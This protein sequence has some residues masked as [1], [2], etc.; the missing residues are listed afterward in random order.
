MNLFT[1]QSPTKSGKLWM[2]ISSEKKIC[3]NPSIS[4]LN[5]NYPAG[6]CRKETSL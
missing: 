5:E 6:G 4:C 2:K 1:E 3:F